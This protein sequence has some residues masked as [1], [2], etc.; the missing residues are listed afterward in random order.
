MILLSAGTAYW[1]NRILKVA[2]EFKNKVMT[3]AFASKQDFSRQLDSFGL[4][5]EGDN[6]VVSVQ[7]DDGSK[8]TMEEKFR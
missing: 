7:S 1:R 8:Y 3:F 2:N 4:N 5:A 6:P